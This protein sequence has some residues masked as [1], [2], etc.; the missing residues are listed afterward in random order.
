MG[1]RSSGHLRYSCQ[2]VTS[3]TRSPDTYA[4]KLIPLNLF[5]L[6][7][8]EASLV[9]EIRKFLLHQFFNLLYSLFESLFA[10]AR[11]MEVQGGGL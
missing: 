11:N 6:P 4:T 5:R 7:P 9:D 1:M 8:A 3:G 10:L 2:H